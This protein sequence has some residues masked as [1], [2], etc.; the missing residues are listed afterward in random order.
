MYCPGDSLMGARVDASAGSL[1]AC[2]RPRPGMARDPRGAS[3]VSVS[4]S[5]A[6]RVARFL[7]RVTHIRSELLLPFSWFISHVMDLKE[8]ERQG[9][10][11]GGRRRQHRQ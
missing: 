8:K 11:E 1:S 10:R 5:R 2:T 4:Q 6:C 3:E 9:G 7:R